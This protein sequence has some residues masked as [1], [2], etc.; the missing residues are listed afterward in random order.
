VPVRVRDTLFLAAVVGLSLVLYVG[1]LGFNSDDWAF[2]GKL[3]TAPDQHNVLQLTQTLLSADA[4]FRPRPVEALNPM[5]YHLVNGAVLALSAG[6]F[7]LVLR[8][9]GCAR[10]LAIS[11]AAVYALLPNYSADRFWISASIAPLSVALYLL[12]LLVDLRL[13]GGR[14][15]R[16][17]PWKSVSLLA[18]LGAGLAYELVI[19]FLPL[20]LLL[21][22]RHA[23]SK[24]FVRAH[25]ALLFGANAVAIL[26]LVVYKLGLS[27]RVTMNQGYLDH[28]VYLVSGAVRANYVTF[29]AGMPVLS[30]W[31]V[32][33][34]LSAA[35]AVVALTLGLL[36]AGYV[37]ASL[38]DDDL[39]RH[40]WSKFILA[41][42][43]VSFWGYAVFLN[44]DNV[45]FA[46]A[47]VDTRTAIVATA[48]VALVLIGAVGW[49]SSRLS[50]R[51]SKLVFSACVSML[52][53]YGFFVVNRLAT[54]WQAAYEE[55][56]SILSEIN[57]QLPDVPENTT[58]IL[59]GTCPEIGPAFV[60]RFNWD[61]SGALATLYHDP[62]L[63]A[64]VVTPDVKVDPS[65]LLIRT[66]RNWDAYTYGSD[67]LVYDSRRKAV[68]ELTDANR[69]RTYF[70]TLRAAP[71]CPPPFSWFA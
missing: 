7:S 61:L 17:W 34:G 1:G 66:F 39:Q 29:V 35:L 16:L 57:Q 3:S 26:A 32:R 62:T 36:V 31:S 9:L 12:S 54:F 53:L 51:V 5:G 67:L 19:P 42:V 38:R 28:L 18:L 14:T 50:P 55:D 64:T 11:S 49:I 59:D 60:F 15:A 37:Y 47:N 40:L 33:G 52:C 2:L 56:L 4:G 65:A 6:L 69:A 20:N 22:W 44:N 43:F 24:A 41:G 13:V 46:T 25:A 45:V 30:W 48:G 10:V 8:E 71:T 68:H 21:M 23:R 70:E 63:K 27:Y 58:L